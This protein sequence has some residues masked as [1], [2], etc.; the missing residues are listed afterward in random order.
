MPPDHSMI[1]LSDVIY[2]WYVLLAYQM[3]ITC[4]I[5]DTKFCLTML[6]FMDLGPMQLAMISLR[7]LQIELHQQTA[8]RPPCHWLELR[9]TAKFLVQ[10]SLFT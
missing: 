1:V 2:A 8:L 3:K 5:S 9:S 6:M 10:N 7:I 4:F